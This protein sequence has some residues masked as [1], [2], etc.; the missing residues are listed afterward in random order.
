MV[1][2][3]S[4]WSTKYCPTYGVPKCG[5]P[6][7]INKVVYH[8]GFPRG[9][10]QAGFL[11]CVAS[12]VPPSVVQQGV[13]TKLRAPRLVPKIG[14]HSVVSAFRPQKGSLQGC[15]RR[16]DQ[17][18]PPKAGSTNGFPRILVSQL[19]YREGV[20]RRDNL[21]WPLKAGPTKGSPKA[22]LPCGFL[23]GVPQRWEP[24]GEPSRWSTNWGPRMGPTR[25]P[26]LGFPKFCP[27]REDPSDCRAWGPP[28]GF[29]TG[30]LRSWVSQGVFQ[31]RYQSGPPRGIPN[32]GNQNG[33]QGR[34]THCCS[35]KAVPQV[36]SRGCLKRGPNKVVNS[37]GSP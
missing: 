8:R 34:V 25:G 28:L 35:L 20:P 4:V 23:Q 3:K 18:R 22:G 7:V 30:V 32:G 11:M 16:D 31:E 1:V 37:R 9:V 33:S 21:E 17:H 19:V 15:T 5:T 14:S 13:S 12:R 24:Q 27:Q 6:I 26:Q 36:Y 10:P 29:P 2:P